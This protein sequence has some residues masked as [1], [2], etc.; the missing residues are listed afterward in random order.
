MGRIPFPAG[1]AYRIQ[2]KAYGGV[3]ATTRRKLEA[4][5]QTGSVT[6]LR[7]KTAL[8]PGAML[9]R[10]YDGAEYRVTV[11]P[12]GRFEHAGR[13]FT[14]LSAVARHITGTQWNGHRFFGLRKE[15]R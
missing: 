4:I 7:R 10:E 15:A 8:A 5:G 9:L 6:G 11:Q 2:A 13:T 3:P 14:S 12:D 1:L